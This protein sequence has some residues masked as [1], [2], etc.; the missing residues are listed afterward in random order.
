MRDEQEGR[1]TQAEINALASAIAQALAGVEAK[2]AKPRKAKASAKPKPVVAV[3][4][5]KFTR[6]A[7]TFTFTLTQAGIRGG[8]YDKYLV[9][10]ER[11][12]KSHERGWKVGA[13]VSLTEYATAKHLDLI[14][15]LTA[16]Y[17]A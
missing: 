4:T 12:G 7:T 10:V 6:G 14:A 15:G 8:A 13:G 17:F 5:N 2:P 1:M 3:A 16:K 11:D 9:R